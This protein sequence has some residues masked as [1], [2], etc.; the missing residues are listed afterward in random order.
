MKIINCAQGTEEWHRCRLGIPTA[1]NF[2]KLL[3]ATGK[4][5]TQATGYMDALLAEMIAGTPNEIEPT[6]WMIRGIEMEQEARDFYDFDTGN[7][8]GEVGFVLAD[9]YGCSPDGLV[10]ADGLLEI[11]CPKRET[12]T[13][14]LRVGKLPTK[15]IPQVQGQMWVCERDWCDF[16]SYCPKFPP[17]VLRIER[18]DKYIS[19][20]AD[21]MA[22]FLE[23][24]E[25]AKQDFIN[26]GY[27]NLDQE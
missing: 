4:P 18:D 27:I 16:V 23:K 15:Y 3:T 6:E 1:S 21:R 7:E 14:Y 10:G 9:G 25:T 24:L 20:L 13:G 5:S 11:K 26:R 8:V 22:W 17:L 12:Q 19:L 2:D